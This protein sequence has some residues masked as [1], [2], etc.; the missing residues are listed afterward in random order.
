MRLFP[1]PAGRHVWLPVLLLALLAGCGKASREL[2]IA[3]AETKIRA[4]LAAR[5]QVWSF[6]ENM[7][8]TEYDQNATLRRQLEALHAKGLLDVLAVAPG[9]GWHVKLSPK[10]EAYRLSDDIGR[11]ILKGEVVV[12]SATR[13]LDRID[14]LGEPRTNSGGAT[15]REASYTWHYSEVT[16]FGEVLGLTPGEQTKASVPAVLFG[17]GWR[18]SIE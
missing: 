4:A 18:F 17:D 2:S 1:N 7:T 11:P 12:R 14:S 15:S 3:D 13:A 6:Q 9:S 10:G 8:R 5:P 16:P